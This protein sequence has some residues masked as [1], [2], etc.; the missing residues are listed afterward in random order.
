MVLWYTAYDWFQPLLPIEQDRLAAYLEGGGRLLF[1]S[2]DYIY[3]LPGHTPDAFTKN[4]LGVEG[5]I[6]DHN[7]IEVIGLMDSFVGNHLGPYPLTFPPGYMNWTDA[8]TPTATAQV[9][10]VGQD[11][12]NNSVFHKGLGSSGNYW[13]T[14][15]LSYGPELLAPTDRA[16]VIQRSMG[17]ISWLG[18]STITPDVSEALDGDTILYTA[19]VTNDGWRDLTTT[20]FTAT[21]SSELTPVSASPDLTLTN[22]NYVW[23]GPLGKHQ[24]KTFTY[25]AQI[26]NALP[27]GTRVSQTSWL[28]YP[29]H[30]ILFDRIADVQVNTPNLKTSTFDVVPNKTL[31]A[32]DTLTYTLVL[33]NDGLVDAPMVTTTNTLPHMLQLLGIDSPSQGNIV[34]NNRIITWTTPLSKNEMA[35]LTYRAIISYQSST[36]IQNTAYANDDLSDQLLLMAEANFKVYPYYFPI[37][38]KN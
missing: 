6:E 37:I 17:W 25:T 22:G 1:S 10:T 35:T 23:S 11:G 16:R 34:H 31:Q 20:H 29:E 38:Y 3:N 36:D 5:H 27:L 26:A 33:K 7:S 2:Q 4:Y 24:S 18:S 14:N 12:Q 15:F 21:F 13:H 32:G 9:A 28:A 30:N 8:L 19:I